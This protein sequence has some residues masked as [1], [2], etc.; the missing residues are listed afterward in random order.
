MTTKRPSPVPTSPPLVPRL[1]AGTS[2]FRAATLLALGTAC[3]SADGDD[4]D[5]MV[6]EMSMGVG[7]AGAPQLAPTGGAP[8]TFPQVPP[9]GTGG[10]PQA[11]GGFGGA[12]QPFPGSGGIPGTGG[13]QV[14]PQL[15][16]WTGGAAGAPQVFP[17]GGAPQAQPAGGAPQVPPQ[18][19]PS[20]GDGNE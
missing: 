12:P 15:P 5:E 6:D 18:A 9:T 4:G 11:S 19:P 20:G 17:G 13:V 3:A 7:G 10:A 2:L 14:F 16:P 8:Q 1:K